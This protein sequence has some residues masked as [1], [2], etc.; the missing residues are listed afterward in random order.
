M[1]VA[2]FAFRLCE[3]I[4]GMVDGLQGKTTYVR[5]DLCRQIDLE[6]SVL[7]ICMEVLC[8]P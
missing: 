7:K 3:G 4:D 6:E 5:R 8:G 1:F 2:S